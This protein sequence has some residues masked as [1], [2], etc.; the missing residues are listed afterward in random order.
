MDASLLAH[1]VSRRAALARAERLQPHQIAD[2]Q[3]RHLRTLREFAVSRSPFYAR[4]HAGLDRAPLADLP[5]LTKTELMGHFD[6]IATDPAVTHRGVT[7]HLDQLREEGGDPGRPWRGRWWAAATGGSTGEPAVIA[8][9]RGEWATVLASYARATRWA[10]VR[11][12]P[13]RPLRVAIVSSLAP[14]HQSAAVGASAR[15]PFVDTVRLDARSPLRH[16]C[17]TLNHFQP[18][19]LVGYASALRALATAQLEGGLNIAPEAVMSASEVLSTATAD[20]LTAAWG[21]P[22]FDVYAATETAGIASTC[23]AGAR[24]LYDDLLIVEPIDAEGLPVPPGT[25]SARTLVTVLFGRTIPLIRYAL[26]DRVTPLA[27]PCTCGLPFSRIGPIGGRA[28][29][30]L[31]ID[32]DGTVTN[33]DAELLRPVIEAFPVARWQLV[34]GRATPELHVVVERPFDTSRLVARLNQVLPPGAR[35]P[36]SVRIMPDLPLTPLGKSRPVS[37]PH[38]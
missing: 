9:E 27:E 17:D 32:T 31:T 30:T 12:G 7:T 34:A 16:L 38:P 13:K 18:R 24:H 1:V 35:R 15:A 29:D 19:V 37:T 6:Q 28:E 11:F 10:D 5:I 36:I 2:R 22:P 25:P 3:A 21:R 20:I 14:T 8:W 26:S 33:V 4:F 23:S